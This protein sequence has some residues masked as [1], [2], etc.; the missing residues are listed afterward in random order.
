MTE[1]VYM[2]RRS[3]EERIHVEIPAEEIPRILA[4]FRPGPEASAET[5]ALHQ[6]LVEAHRAFGREWPGGAA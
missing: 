4:D 5:L 1:R 6:V 3:G 2:N